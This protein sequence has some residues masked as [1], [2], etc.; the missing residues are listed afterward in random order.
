MLRT[1]APLNT[2]PDPRHAPT[3]SQRQP[4]RKFSSKS[5]DE[6]WA[7]ANPPL[8]RVLVTVSS[9]P[10]FSLLLQSRETLVSRFR[11]SYAYLSSV[12]PF[13]RAAIRRLLSRTLADRSSARFLPQVSARQASERSHVFISR[14]TALSHQVGQ[15]RPTWPWR[16]RG[17]P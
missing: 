5:A 17:L 10:V 1:F 16:R 7:E 4:P 15:L 6:I 14:S 9:L 3:Q 11:A 13:C 12:E 8:Q 2:H